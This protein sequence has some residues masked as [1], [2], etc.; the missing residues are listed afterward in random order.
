MDD[1]LKL[2]PE[3]IFLRGL[4]D[5]YHRILFYLYPLLSGLSF[6]FIS[7]M[8][9]IKSRAMFALM[10]SSGLRIGEVCRLRYED[11]DRKTC[12][13]IFPIPKH[14]RT[15]MPLCPGMP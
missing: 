10:Y 12:A 8:P 1:Y 2:F 14:G 13:S 11:I 4:T 3:M 6:Q 5:H 9:G 7:T 15:A